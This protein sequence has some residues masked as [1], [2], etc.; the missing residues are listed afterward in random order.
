MNDHMPRY[1]DGLF[2]VTPHVI[3]VSGLKYGQGAFITFTPGIK[4]QFCLLPFS[5]LFFYNPCKQISTYE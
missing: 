1:P 2:E 5:S 4:G 3:S